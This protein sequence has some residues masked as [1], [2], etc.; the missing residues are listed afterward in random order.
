M[1]R[2]KIMWVVAIL[3]VSVAMKGAVMGAYNFAK[4]WKAVD[5]AQENGLPRT[6]TNKVEEIAREAA[7]AA[8]WPDAARAF[9]VR[10]QAMKEFRD[11][12]PQDWLQTLPVRISVE[13][14]LRQSYD[15]EA[16]AGTDG[17]GSA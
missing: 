5:E 1:S 8:R 17:G 13:A 14:T 11:E 15:M 4:A 9:L 6:V 10:E 7:A 2:K 16:R 3:A 12:L